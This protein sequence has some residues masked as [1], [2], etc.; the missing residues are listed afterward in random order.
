VPK[1][2]VSG[3]RPSFGSALLSQT[4][5]KIW[6]TYHLHHQ[7]GLISP[8]LE[9]SRNPIAGIPHTEFLSGAVTGVKPVEASSQQESAGPLM[10]LGRL[11]NAM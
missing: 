3:I 1:V 7:T 9:R 2:A 4:E 8:V 10:R 6:G 11:Q 5:V